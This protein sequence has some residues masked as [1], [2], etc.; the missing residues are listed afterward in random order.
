[1]NTRVYNY[2]W[3]SRLTATIL[4]FATEPM[5]EKYSSNMASVTLQ[6]RISKL[7]LDF[8]LNV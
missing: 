2:F 8:N 7:L 4:M 5:G 3:I 1:M 6:E